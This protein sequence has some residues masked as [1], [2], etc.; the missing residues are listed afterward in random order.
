MTQATAARQRKLSLNKRTI[1]KLNMYMIA[2]LNGEITTD[3][4][5]PSGK[6]TQCQPQSKVKERNTDPPTCN[7]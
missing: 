7:C 6:P 1:M 3:D 4:E 5:P 2:G